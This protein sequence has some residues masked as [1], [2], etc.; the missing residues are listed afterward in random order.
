MAE[1]RLVLS[2]IND[3]NYCIDEL[4]QFLGEKIE[5]GEKPGIVPADEKGTS[6][7]NYKKNRIAIHS[8]NISDGSAYFEEAA[9]FLRHRIGPE[10]GENANKCVQEFFGRL[11]EEIGRVIVDDSHRRLFEGRAPRHYS[12]MSF[13][14]QK[15]RDLADDIADTNNSTDTIQ[16]QLNNA[17]GLFELTQDYYNSMLRTTIE[18]CDDM[19]FWK[20]AHALAKMRTDYDKKVAEIGK[21][22]TPSPFLDHFQEF[23]FERGMLYERIQNMQAQVMATEKTENEGDAYQYRR[24]ASEH[25]KKV[26]ESLKMIRGFKLPLMKNAIDLH[27]RAA[28]MCS[29]T[30]AAGGIDA[31]MHHFGYAAAE[32]YV[33][34]NP[35]WLEKAPELFRQTDEFMLDSFIFTE[36]IKPYV[37]KHRQIMAEK[38]LNV[39]E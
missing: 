23:L 36:E 1:Q 30:M 4:A 18:Y 2:A 12:D 15:V 20:M 25:F 16:E 39:E 28:S 35:D 24:N 11:A 33:M 7:Y 8:D 34:N 37:E 21:S 9:H 32:L 38:G 31:N 17:A 26:V 27:A 6:S 5:A 3:V 22:E 29:M 13:F 10:Q 19:N 14:E